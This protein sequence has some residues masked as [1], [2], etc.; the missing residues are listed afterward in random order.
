MRMGFGKS[1][2]KIGHAVSFWQGVEH[3]KPDTAVV[4]PNWSS[5]FEE[6]GK[7]YP[8][9]P[10]IEVMGE[11]EFRKE[12]G[13]GD[14]CKFLWDDTFKFTKPSFEPRRYLEEPYVT[15]HTVAGAPQRSFKGSTDI[16]EESGLKVVNLDHMRVTMNEFHQIIDGAERH[17]GINSGPA[18]VAASVGTP[19]TLLEF[20]ENRTDWSGTPQTLMKCKGSVRRNI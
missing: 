15:Y 7:L 1:N 17:Y 5:L 11:A 16:A 10:K 14:E 6:V 2:H 13:E 3:Y 4:W 9:N 12:F 19:I 8:S 20:D 18:W